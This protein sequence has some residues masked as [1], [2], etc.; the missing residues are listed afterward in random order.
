[1]RVAVPVSMFPWHGGVDFLRHVLG[2]LSAVSDVQRVDIVFLLPVTNRIETPLDVVS[3]VKQ[4]LYMSIRER[5][6]KV[7]RPITPCAADVQELHQALVDA[8]VKCCR[9]VNTPSGFNRAVH[10]AGADVVMP[11]NG[12]LGASSKVPWV[13]YVYDFQ[14]KYFKELFSTEECFSRDI[15][16][17]Q[18]LRDAPALIVNSRA[19]RDDIARWF[20]YADLS[21]V[22][23]LPFAPYA[24]AEW[25]VS[26]LEQARLTY[27]LPERYFAIC[28]QFWQHKNHLTAFSALSQLEDDVALVC[29]GDTTDYRRPGYFSELMAQAEGLGVACRIRCLGRIPKRDQIEI[30][31]GA[32]ALIQPTLFEGGPGGGSVY[33]AVSIG[34]PAI[35]SDIPVNREIVADNVFWFPSRNAQALAEAMTSLLVRPPT[36]PSETTLRESSERNQQNLGRQ[37]VRAIHY[38]LQ[39]QT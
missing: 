10:R 29:T 17:A 20:P 14:H 19:V 21:R 34:T 32:V 39:Q 30:I 24:P 9:Y 15:H 13:G 25:L 37:L 11:V 3:V 4:S 5:K 38:T 28:N 26:T 1:M 2:G 35:V 23:V 22:F 8:G 6:L 27:A 16:F 33:D 18:V 7:A 31:R 36:R 12:T